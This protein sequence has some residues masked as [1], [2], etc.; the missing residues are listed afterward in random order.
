MNTET[1]G[2][3][4]GAVWTALNTADAPGVKQIKK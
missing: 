4:A 1:I 3:N 2:M